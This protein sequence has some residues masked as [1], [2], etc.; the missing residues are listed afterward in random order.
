MPPAGPV[1]PQP[2][3]P[4]VPR[5]PFRHDVGDEHR[6]V[7]GRQAWFA[8][9]RTGDIHPV[10]PGVPGQDHIDEVAEQRTNAVRPASTNSAGGSS[11]VAAVVRRMT[12]SSS[13][14]PRSNSASY[15]A[16]LPSKYP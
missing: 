15:S 14:Q 7:V 2:V 8:A 4:A 16:F 6:V 13:V 10:H 11:V 1:S 12:A 9:R 5:R 3:G